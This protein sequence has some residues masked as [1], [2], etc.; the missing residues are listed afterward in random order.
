MPETGSHSN[1]EEIV[2]LSSARESLETESFPL[3]RKWGHPTLLS[4]RITN[5]NDLRR[6]NLPEVPRSG[7]HR[8][9]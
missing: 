9:Q 6:R 4:E 3:T 1:D 5:D 2:G 8:H 7:N